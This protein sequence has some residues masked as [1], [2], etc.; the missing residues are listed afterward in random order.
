MDHIILTRKEI[1][2]ALD[3]EDSLWAN[4]QHDHILCKRIYSKGWLMKRTKE[5]I[6][7]SNINIMA[8]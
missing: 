3:F 1:A 7:V 8:G 4:N 6:L 5:N 2:V